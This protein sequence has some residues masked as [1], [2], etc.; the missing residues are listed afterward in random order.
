VDNCD[1][2]PMKRHAHSTAC[3]V[4]H[5]Q[6]AI[7]IHVYSVCLDA[8]EQYRQCARPIFSGCGAPIVPSNH[9]NQLSETYKEAENC[10]YRRVNVQKLIVNNNL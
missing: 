3:M 7:A 10:H 5:S 4:I 2:L 8:I 6:H 1:G 9:P